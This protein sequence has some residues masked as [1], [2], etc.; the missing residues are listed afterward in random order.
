MQH[1]MR[2][3]YVA[4]GNGKAIAKCSFVFRFHAPNREDNSGAQVCGS[5]LRADPQ[6]TPA[7]NQVIY[8]SG[9][10]RKYEFHNSLSRTRKAF[11]LEELLQ[12]RSIIMRVDSDLLGEP[13]RKKQKAVTAKTEA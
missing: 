10:F 2:Q 8:S 1:M 3:Q 4:C 13:P 7:T 6:V 5:V 12:R 9:Y 11:C